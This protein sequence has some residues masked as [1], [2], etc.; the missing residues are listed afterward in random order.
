MTLEDL[1]A[2]LIQE[3][4]QESPA[5][6]RL[7]ENEDAL[8]RVLKAYE[9][10][11]ARTVRAVLDQLG[12]ARFCIP[13]C[14]WLCVW[15]CIRVCRLI[16]RE[17]PET[18]FEIP[19]LHTYG[20]ALGK[21]ATDEKAARQLFAAVE[22]ADADAFHQVVEKYELHAFCYLLCYWICI[23]RCRLFCRLV[24]PPIEI[25]VD[26]DPFEEFLTAAKAVGT[27]AENEDLFVTALEAYEARDAAK[28]RAV[29]EQLQLIP[30][31]IILCRWLCVIHCHRI[32]LRICPKI[33][34]RFTPAE[35]RELA[36]R[37]RKLASEERTLDRLVA[38]FRDGDDKAFH[39]I[40]DQFGLGRFC[41]FIC[42]WL[43][44]VHCG[45]YCRIICPPSLDCRIDEPKG[46]T[47]EEV[48]QDLKAYVVP[49]R[50]TASGGNFDHYTLEWS[51]DNTLWHADSFHYPPIPPGGGTQGNSPVVNA[52]LAYFDTTAHD[53]GPYFL[54]LTVYAKNG[55]TKV[56]TTSFSLF[57][58][59]VRIL[60]AS[61]FT[62]LDKPAL[63][64]D[65]RFVETFTPKCASTG[66]VVEVSFAHCVS[67]QG[68]AFVGG[69]D[70]KKIK[71][72][73]LSYKSGH[74]ISCAAPGWTEFWKIEYST[75]WQYRD[76]NM[77]TDTDSLTSV[78]VTDCVVPWPFPPYCLASQPEA[79]LSPSCWQTRLSGCQ[80]SG[81]YTLKLD[82]ED[83]DG[84]HYCDLQRIWLDN[85][86][87]HGLLRIDAVPSCS[88]LKL[89]QFAN[90][91]DCSNPWAL[92]LVGIAYDE[93]I[94]ETL[95]VNQRP[96]DNFD[97]YWIK[98]AR[99]GGPE[100]QIPIDAA[101][102]SCFYGTQRVG[103]P[104]NRCQG[105]P[106]ADILGKLADFDLRAVD[107]MC[108]GATS[109]AGSIPPGFALNRGECCVYTFRMKVY[110]TT[111]FSGG[112]HV[113]EPTPW[114]VKI[115]N[116]L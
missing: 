97:H 19:E 33:P 102:G 9:A 21:L 44:H 81:L 14:R 32:C 23:L 40:L 42:R 67:V 43:C 99:Q 90:P 37:W 49:V 4:A 75:I 74:E 53:A 106:A 35:I 79:R 76:M 48:S 22:K 105:P 61:G 111:K 78:W 64:P 104:G 87:I 1:E 69:C 52:L 107:A 73:S 108:S 80:L 39:A 56:C 93:Y 26:L 13:I 62:N 96:N 100:V 83:V 29:F 24:C 60:G 58:Q 51:P 2:Q 7:A 91:P 85:K 112:P 28:V 11:D 18:P 88:D 103:L 84:N 30:F 6:A 41:F 38:S 66:S 113:A 54:R 50:G 5:L 20:L 109:Y 71:R 92:P 12:L 70:D 65:A 94:D 98:V 95:P 86:P 31:C 115:C 68:S 116:D 34:R 55:A 63:D 45:L 57:K 8:A 16:C 110:D 25:P 82:V 3:L 72:Y 36:L 27:L 77:R 114:P 89:S 17:V 15:E 47:A 10:Q 46:C 59:D 101:D